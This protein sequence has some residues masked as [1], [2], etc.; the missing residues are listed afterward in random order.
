M[1]DIFNIEISLIEVFVNA[2][3]SDFII[4]NDE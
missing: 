3:I 1:N 4:I 2:E